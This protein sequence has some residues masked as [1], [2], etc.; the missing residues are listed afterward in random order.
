[1]EV[2]NVCR[3]TG[4]SKKNPDRRKTTQKQKQGN[5]GYKDVFRDEMKSLNP[6]IWEKTQNGWKKWR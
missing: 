6:V 5:K 2:A 4:Q 1:M 3:T